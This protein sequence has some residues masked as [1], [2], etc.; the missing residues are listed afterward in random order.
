M[1]KL[2]VLI[3]VL[4]T[5]GMVLS[6]CQQPAAPA[7]APQPEVP[8]EPGTTAPETTEPET[9]APAVEFAKFLDIVGKTTAAVRG[10]TGLARDI[11]VLNSK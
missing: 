8:A 6:A 3:A 2:Y 7:E 5:L 11:Q 9:T 1:R 10:G 4:L